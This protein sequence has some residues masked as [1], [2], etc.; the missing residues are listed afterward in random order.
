MTPVARRAAVLGSPIGH[1]LSP[2]LHRAAYA[3]LGLDWRY[4]ALDVREDEL[5]EFM[6]SLDDR[7][8]GLSLTMPLKTA[9]LP[10]LH[11]TS[12]TVDAVGAANTVVVRDGRRH[13][14]NT[15]VMG[16]VRAIREMAPH[17]D[18]SRATILGGGAT[19]GSAIAALDLLGIEVAYAALRDP[20]KGAHLVRI[21]AGLGR[22]LRIVSW[23]EAHHHLDADLVVSTVPGDAAD[24]Y[25]QDVPDDPG[26]LLDVAYGDQAGH[27]VPAWRARGGMAEGGLPLLLWQAADQV[28]LMTGQEPPVDAM[29]TALEAAVARE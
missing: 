29:R 25:A 7:W 6:D 27:L 16:M 13:G 9:V 17:A 15:D 5:A 2:V 1:S 12:P 23:E 8:V 10:L 28:R 18:L 20:A 4:D 26:I 11:D 3:A 21:A 14:H 19:A 22:D 24:R